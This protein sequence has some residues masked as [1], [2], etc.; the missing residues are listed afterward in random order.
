MYKDIVIS[1]NL[2]IDNLS[3]LNCHNV[4][5]ALLVSLDLRPQVLIKPGFFL[6]INIKCSMW[7]I[8]HLFIDFIHFFFYKHIFFWHYN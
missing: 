5:L 2:C 7:N 8:L 6:L 1:E 3:M 4:Q